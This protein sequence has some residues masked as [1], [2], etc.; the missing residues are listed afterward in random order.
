MNDQEM[1]E[2]AAKA[3]GIKG[4]C[5]EVNGRL[6]IAEEAPVVGSL[7]YYPSPPWCPLTDDRDAFRLALNL[8]ISTDLSAGHMCVAVTSYGWREAVA[9]MDRSECLRRAI[10][11]AAADHEKKK[12][13]DLYAS[14]YVPK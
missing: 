4:G 14:Q 10:V 9:G 12:Q 5:Y 11:G 2:L 8:N 6:L 7:T 1:L 3:A 13:R